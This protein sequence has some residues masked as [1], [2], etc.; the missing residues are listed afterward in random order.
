[1]PDVD[2]RGA[3]NRLAGVMAGVAKRLRTDFETS[4]VIEHRGSKGSVREGFI[5]DYLAK[6]LPGSVN[7]IG[8]GEIIDI[9][10]SV[11]RQCDVLIV[12]PSTPPLYSGDREEFHV[13]YAE[14]VYCVIEVKSN[15]TTDELIKACENIKSVKQLKKDAF[16]PDPRGP[17]L[18]RD[19]RTFRYFPTGG[20]IFA[21]D[22]A[23]LKTLGQAFADW[24][25]RV[26]P[27]FRPDSV[28][29]LGKG[30]LSWAKEPA[31]SGEWGFTVFAEKGRPL[32]IL[33]AGESEVLLPL[34]LRLHAMLQSTF[35]PPFDLSAYAGE[36]TIG[37]L[38]EGWIL[39]EPDEPDL[40]W[41]KK[42]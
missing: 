11:S 5:T 16:R 17:R 14:C 35:M 31:S 9:H 7:A 34:T 13:V 40:P 30:A 41:S 19:G 12:D 33:Y 42:S 1:M 8:S 4:A 22:G 38:G 2:D 3:N 29:V 39:D 25:E 37:T 6:Y 20:V 32:G 10:G 24:C 23:S 26:D 28:W 21:Y 36:L 15:L 27:D 18:T